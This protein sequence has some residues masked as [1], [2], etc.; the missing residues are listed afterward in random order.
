MTAYSNIIMFTDL[1]GTLLDEQY[2][3]AAA[4]PALDR[5]AELNI[6]LVLCSSKTRAE[7]EHYRT[8]LGNTQPFISEN[9]GGIFLPE[10]YFHGSDTGGRYPLTTDQRYRVISLGTPYGEL[11]CALT[12]LR[13]EGF[14]VTGFG[15]MTV[16]ELAAETGLS[17]A[18]ARLCKIREFDEPF[19]F[20]GDEQQRNALFRAIRRRGLTTTQ[21]VY[22]HLLGANDK[23]A[24]VRLL[25]R[26]LQK[27]LGPLTSIALGDSPNDLPMLQSVT[28]PVIVQRPNGQHHPAL[29]LP[30]SYRAPGIGPAGWNSAVL[31]LLAQYR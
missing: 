21:G 12:E 20:T 19:L 17:P 28:I 6:P 10:G 23:G 5:V 30:D 15:D 22:H 2:S 31:D 9:G 26:M 13:R 4:Q 16:A 24:A 11:R 8:L 27:Q 29:A 3:F 7:L 25:S 14:P 1:D 18:E